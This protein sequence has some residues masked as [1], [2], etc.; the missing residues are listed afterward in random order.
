[1]KASVTGPILLRA[2]E[3]LSSAPSIARKKI[4]TRLS[5]LPSL[6]TAANPTGTLPGQRPR[7][8][9]RHRIQRRAPRTSSANATPPMP[10]Y[11]YEDWTGQNQGVGGQTLAAAGYNNEYHEDDLTLHVDSTLSA[12]LL[13]QF[14]LVGEHDFSHNVNAA[15]APRVSVAGYFTAGSAQNDAL[16]AP[17]TTSASTT[18]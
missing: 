6:P 1:M 4:W 18:W 7:A 10:Q 12:V 13:N 5:T 17:N 14:S 15:E 16:S 2:K 9:A 11:S 3:Q 8:D